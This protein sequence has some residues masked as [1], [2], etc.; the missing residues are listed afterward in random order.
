MDEY[1]TD[2]GEIDYDK[3]NPIERDEYLKMLSVVEGSKI[4]LED[5]KK[6]I[7]TM[8]QALE[9]A[10]LKEPDFIYSPIIP[11]FKRH[12]T[13]ILYIKA[14]LQNYLIFEGL[15][16]R[17]DLAKAQLEAYKKRLEVK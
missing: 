16:D 14:R 5:F 6:H 13:N 4:T 11:F 7:K 15:F 10:L 2:S 1:L 12:N 8:R 17:P 3:L 9:S